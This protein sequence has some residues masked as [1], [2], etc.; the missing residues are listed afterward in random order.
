MQE[1]K[2][3]YSGLASRPLEVSSS[4]ERRGPMITS[5]EVV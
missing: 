4:T 1:R 2:L 5:R 3:D